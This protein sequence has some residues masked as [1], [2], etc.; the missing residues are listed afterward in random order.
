MGLF[1]SSSLHFIPSKYPINSSIFQ[2]TVT[3]SF[4]TY[5]LSSAASILCVRFSAEY[6][7]IFSECKVKN[8]ILNFQKFF[9][10]FFQNL[11]GNFQNFSYARAIKLIFILKINFVKSWESAIPRAA[12]KDEFLVFE[13]SENF[14]KK[15][16]KKFGY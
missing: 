10:L 11:F 12:C 3:F 9:Q 15:V 5:F 6:S 16:Q 13:N 2:L 7:A 8:S 14:L 4:N 1:F